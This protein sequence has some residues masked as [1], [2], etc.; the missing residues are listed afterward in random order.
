MRFVKRRELPRAYFPT[1]MAT[2][3]LANLPTAASLSRNGAG[4][5][6]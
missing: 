6:R 4:D 1:G 5:E 3:Q 2:V